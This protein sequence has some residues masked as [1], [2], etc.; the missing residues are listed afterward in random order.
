MAVVG[1]P[2]KRSS[3]DSLLD[4]LDLVLYKPMFLPGVN[5]RGAPTTSGDDSRGSVYTEGVLGVGSRLRE[6]PH[7]PSD[8]NNGS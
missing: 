2:C 8:T 7:N 5:G 1:E 4:S 3:D 6:R